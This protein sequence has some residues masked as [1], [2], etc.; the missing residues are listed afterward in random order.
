MYYYKG[1]PLYD[2]M[3]LFSEFQKL[4]ERLIAR[5][6]SAD[7]LNP[8]HTEKVVDADFGEKEQ[9][10]L[11]NNLLV[12]RVSLPNQI[13]QRVHQAIIR[14]RTKRRVSRSHRSYATT[15]T[16]RFCKVF[17]RTPSG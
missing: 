1:T 12:A 6:K 8:Q 7:L 16:V 10:V 14:L 4:V 9:E 11:Y 17:Y 15:N 2:R 5:Y 3:F 13:K